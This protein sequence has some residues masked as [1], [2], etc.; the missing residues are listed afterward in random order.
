[1][2]ELPYEHMYHACAIW[3]SYHMNICTMHVPYEWATLWTYIPCVI[4][5]S[6]HMNICTMH[7]PY[8]WATLWTYIPCAIWMSYHMN[9]CTMHVPYEWA[10]IWTY[11]PCM[12][13]MNELPYEHMYHACAIWMSYHMNIYTKCHMNELPYEHMYHVPYEWATIWTYDFKQS[14]LWSDNEL[15]R[16][17]PVVQ[18]VILPAPT[19]VPIRE[20][21]DQFKVRFWECFDTAEYVPVW[22]SN[23]HDPKK[24]LISF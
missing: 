17:W 3:M 20:S 16:S 21:V 13:Q 12:C 18:I 8:E 11:V 9:I 14:S 5:M 7:V 24:D 15:K 6:Y 23:K 10:T 22:Q 1:M 2:N 19:E 4:W